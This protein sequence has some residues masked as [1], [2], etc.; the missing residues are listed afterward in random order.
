M[1]IGSDRDT[2]YIGPVDQARQAMSHLAKLPAAK[3]I[4]EILKE[5]SRVA[6]GRGRGPSAMRPPTTMGWQ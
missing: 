4:R 3:G 2:P 1:I 6:Q 5:K